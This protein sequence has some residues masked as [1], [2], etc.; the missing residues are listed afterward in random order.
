MVNR[1]HNPRLNHQTAQTKVPSFCAKRCFPVYLSDF[2][3]TQT[4]V[5][6]P[7]TPLHRQHKPVSRSWRRVVRQR[8][9]LLT[10]AI[11][12]LSVFA[13]VAHAKSI[14]VMQAQLLKTESAWMALQEQ[15]ASTNRKA[16]RA[17]VET[18]SQL[19]QESSTRVEVRRALRILKLSHQTKS[20]E[21]VT[22]S[23][24]TLTSLLDGNPTNGDVHVYWD[25]EMKWMS[26]PALVL[27]PET[28]SRHKPYDPAS[29]E[30]RSYGGGY[31]M[32]SQGLLAHRH[33]DD[34]DGGRLD[35]N[36]ATTGVLVQSRGG[37]GFTSYQVGDLL[38]GT[39]TGGL[40]RLALGAAGTVLTSSGGV[41]KW[42]T[43]TVGGSSGAFG[44]GN[45]IILGDSR[46]LRRSGGTVTG[47]MVISVTNGDSNALGLR[48][49]NTISGAALRTQKLLATSGALIIKRYAG[50]ST[51]N[52]LIVD[53][54][55]LVYDAGNKRVGIGTHTPSSILD[56]VSQ[57]ATFATFQNA[58]HSLKL[59]YDLIGY[60]ELG[61][62]DPSTDAIIA[63]TVPGTD[64]FLYA[65]SLITASGGM[66]GIARTR[67]RAT[68]DV[69]GTISGARLVINGSI[70][71]TG[72]LTSR[73][74]ITFRSL[75]GCSAL[76]TNSAGVVSCGSSTVFG[77][78]NVLAAGDAR[79][80]KKSGD[81]MTGALTI[82]NGN[83]HSATATPLLHVRGTISGSA[84]ITKLIDINNVASLNGM[85]NMVPSSTSKR[86]FVLRKPSGYNEYLLRTEDSSGNMQFGVGNDT[87][88]IG[89]E[90]S[91]SPFTMTVIG[92]TNGSGLG[93]LFVK[94]TPAGTI[95]T[96]L[97]LDS[98][99]SGGK[100]FTFLSSG[101]A[102]SPGAGFFAIFNST[103]VYY[104]FSMRYDDRFYFQKQLW[105]DLGARLNI[106]PQD[107]SE[108]AIVIRQ[109]A[110]TVA[111]PL[112][113][114]NSAGTVLSSMSQSGWLAIGKT[115]KATTQLE[116]AGTF[117]G[118]ALHV[119]GNTGFGTG[120]SLTAKTTIFTTDDFNNPA[121][122]IKSKE[123]SATQDLFRIVSDF[124]TPNNTVYRITASGATY[125]DA[126]FNSAGADY[127]EWFPSD[128]AFPLKPGDSVCLDTL[129]QNQVKR[130]ERDADPNI[131]GIVSTKPSFVGN[132]VAGG[133]LDASGLPIP[134]YTLVGL[135]GQLDSVATIVGSGGV[136]A[137]GDSLTSSVLPG[138]LRRA[139]PGEST[140]GVA[141]TG[142]SNTQGS[143]RVL[144]ARSNKSLTVEAV[145][146]RVRDSVAALKIDDEIRQSFE[147]AL[148]E[149]NVQRR[150]EAE[151]QHQLSL[152]GSLSSRLSGMEEGLLL[153][154]E[155]MGGLNTKLMV[156][157][158]LTLTGSLQASDIV[159]ENTLSVGRDARIA[160][161][162]YLDGALR[163]NALLIPGG[164]LIDG[165]VSTGK[166]HAAS[167]SSISGLLQVEG[168][169]T[170]AGRLL[171]AKG[172]VLS[173]DELLVRG[174]LAVQGPVTFHELAT[175]LSNVAI[176][177]QL[178]LSNRQAGR[179]QLSEGASSINVVFAEPLTHTPVVTV[180]PTSRI[181]DFYWTSNESQT[182]F[183]LVL[184]N[185]ARVA[186]RFSWLAMIVHDEAA[187]QTTAPVAFTPEPA[188]LVFP[189]DANG[190]PTSSNTIWN[191][192]IRHQ[193]PLDPVSGE[194]FSCSRYSPELYTWNH[195]DFP[196][197]T[198]VWNDSYESP[199]L[200]LP[201]G[202]HAQQIVETQ[203][204]SA[205]SIDSTSSNSSSESST[206]EDVT[207]S[208]VN[209][210]SSLSEHSEESPQAEDT[211]IDSEVLTETNTELN[212]TMNESDEVHN[213]Q[214]EV[215]QESHS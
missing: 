151:V 175:F 33:T 75:S 206:T 84:L 210:D 190:V 132:A 212:E 203:F 170:L 87:V 185:P 187:V 2:G 56:V 38:I 167:G 53:T 70:T 27:E 133:T 25:G 202:F 115:G 111:N 124:G 196:G 59:G 148:S 120:R 193:Q 85:I 195:P 178:S 104:P 58:S 152:T 211:T 205:S 55:G 146:D 180:T 166:L 9:E 83:T 214:E 29:G 3:L 96:A 105:T 39:S 57:D 197:M 174:A 163:T 22:S 119:L 88:F 77:T 158:T 40:V 61:L 20:S 97:T 44:S 142:L 73:G 43:P 94:S 45:V 80:V 179:L 144:I 74:T 171:L 24:A 113:V 213:P 103:D 140:V 110:N 13:I 199:L 160:G 156:G 201:Q 155:M 139:L 184:A 209:N 126:P 194:P 200:V 186:T 136:I 7:N 141:L 191:A 19:F 76:S 108:K 207:S 41:A 173:A 16:K 1:M 162:L 35:I 131:I 92:N 188:E 90:G 114:Q 91:A 12:V 101:P 150:I 79:Y 26:L 118:S 183:T 28:P 99:P 52:I 42:I 161:D 168:D 78:G 31:S 112:E 147:Q 66:V 93:P 50:S 18:R 51:G 164:V 153:L 107:S 71:A 181:A 30:P 65:S 208:S 60:G 81:T 82:Q 10:I 49:A 123:S 5:I 4:S 177:G 11:G 95:G 48:V 34:G 72:A 165:T 62:I 17:T 172:A 182:G 134:G 67:P 116:I 117:S 137:P 54:I 98:E 192:C 6:Y 176:R 154:R 138:M 106:I 204:S 32:V 145:E 36:A 102:A 215:L 37:V 149:S 143:I 159:S 21:H 121:L 68:L 130:C 69:G 127:A 47:A 109:V 14:A 128:P 169:L 86:G 157:E 189:V 15:P 89:D 125:A 8:K 64:T 129:R 135:I 63:A 23:S 122:L 198:F 100:K 46:Y